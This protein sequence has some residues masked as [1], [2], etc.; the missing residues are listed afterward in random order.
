MSLFACCCAFLSICLFLK[1][2][3]VNCYFVSEQLAYGKKS[4]VLLSLTPRLF[5]KRAVLF[6][7]NQTLSFNL[8]VSVVVVITLL[9]GSK[10]IYRKEKL[11]RYVATLSLGFLLIDR[12]V[13][14]NEKMKRNLCIFSCDIET[15]SY[16]ALARAW[17]FLF[18]IFQLHQKKQLQVVSVNTN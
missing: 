1:V 13:M 8:T 3:S 14:N 15:N 4:S 10:E 7:W 12:R 11:L 16:V 18:F 9:G 6:S 5:S 2:P 17:T